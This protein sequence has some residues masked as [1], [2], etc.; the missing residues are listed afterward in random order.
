MQES[1]LGGV[2]MSELTTAQVK[3]LAQIAKADD[4]AEARRLCNDFLHATAAQVQTYQTP[5]KPE[6]LLWHLLSAASGAEKDA[7]QVFQQLCGRVY[8]SYSLLVLDSDSD[9]IEPAATVV[10]GLEHPDAWCLEYK[11]RLVCLVAS[12]S[13]PANT[14]ALPQLLRKLNL[15]CGI[16]RP[17]QSLAV[18]RSAYEEG[19]TTLKTLRT[20]QRK[21]AMAYYDDFLM[22]RLLDCIREDVDLSTFCLPD[23]QALQEYD[24]Q[25]DTELCRTLLCYLEYAKNAGNTASKL[26][27][28][29]NTVHYR[30]NK[31]MEI[32][33]GLDFS[34]AYMS[35]LLMLS[36]HIAE[37]G[38]YRSQKRQAEDIL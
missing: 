3:Q 9:R 11:N 15:S 24:R 22:I 12:I 36:L 26:N 14:T 23:I 32:M 2:T 35:F 4:L 28:H 8:E 31:C 34:N 25:H 37:Y 20:L 29:R 7:D 38:Y 27:V 21:Q 30:V 6:E 10:R 5:R 1:T 19:I 17:F 33:K 16:S 18:L 13:G